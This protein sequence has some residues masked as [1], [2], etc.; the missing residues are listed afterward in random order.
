MRERIDEI[1]TVIVKIADL[2][3]AQ[4]LGIVLLEQFQQPL[5]ISVQEICLDIFLALPHEQNKGERDF[6]FLHVPE[7][8]FTGTAGKNIEHIV[9]DLENGSEIKAELVEFLPPFH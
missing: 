1:Y 7:A 3:Q 2:F 9:T 4:Y 8:V 6:P 5:V